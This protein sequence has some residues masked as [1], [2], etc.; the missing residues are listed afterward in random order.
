MLN[1]AGVSPNHIAFLQELMDQ[2]LNGFFLPFECRL[3]DPRKA[4][5]R[6]KA[7]KQVIAQSRVCLEIR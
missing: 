7:D 5:V 4:G 3:A 1:I 2:G 6:M